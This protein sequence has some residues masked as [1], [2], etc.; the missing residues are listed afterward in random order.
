VIEKNQLYPISCLRGISNET[1]MR[2]VDAGIVLIKQV[3][4]HDA[5]FFER[6]LGLPH[7][8]VVSLMEKANHIAKT[9]W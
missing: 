4:E 9:L 5:D 7:Q 8:T 2:L 1:R 6:K 3:L